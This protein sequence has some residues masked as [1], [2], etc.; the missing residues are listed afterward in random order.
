MKRDS[1]KQKEESDSGGGGG[2]AWM[3]TFSDLSTL[4]LTFFVLLLSMSTLDKRAFHSA[5]HNF[6]SSNGVLRFRN[7]NPI[8]LRKTLVLQNICKSLQTVST[9]DT[10]P[11]R[12]FEKDMKGSGI[13]KHF[14]L[15]VP[16]GKGI[17]INPGKASDKFTFIFSDKLLFAS[18]SST[19]KPIADVILAKLAKF[20]K[21]PAYHA[22]IDGHTDNIPIHNKEFASNNAL[23][24]A[25]AMAVMNY[26]IE[27]GGV[28]PKH[29]AAGGYGS[30]QPLTTNATPQGRA[31][32]RRVEIIFQITS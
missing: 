5:F 20:L 7:Y 18:G 11:I 29:L 31:R 17:W 15:L 27:Q 19:L 13:K 30:S 21:N 4:L 12:R 26:L 25:R 24:L 32:N 3:V 23:S 6:N 10:Q 28:N 22:F 8:T 14:N 1:R 16:S 2:A 9:F